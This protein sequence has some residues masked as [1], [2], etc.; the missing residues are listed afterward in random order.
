[1]IN[2]SR[3]NTSHKIF[4]LTVALICL[5]FALWSALWLWSSVLTLR[6]EAIINQWEKDLGDFDKALAVEMIKRLNQSIAINNSDAKTHLLLAKYYEL[7]AQN[8]VNQYS[9][10]AE[11]A[12]KSAVKHQPTWDYT[13]SS[14][15]SFYSKQEP[16][17]EVKLISSLSKAMLLGPYEHKNQKLLIPLIFKHWQLLSNIESEKLIATK[18]IKNA[19]KY[20]ITALHTLNSAKEYQ[21]LSILEP[22]LS[23]QWHKKR[24][25]KYLREDANDR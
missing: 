22:M 18:V 13:W 25:K 17:N 21:Q 5:I 24:L 15:A 9:T 6:P 8:Q 10:L 12:F 1:M 4:A 2:T 3:Q 7:L 19:L 11:Q 16:L 23:Q 20:H 14:L